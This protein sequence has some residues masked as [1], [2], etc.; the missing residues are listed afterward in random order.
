MTRMPNT[1]ATMK[2]DRAWAKVGNKHYIHVSGNEVSYDCNAW[3][4]RVNS[5]NGYTTLWV[6]KYEAERM[7]A[8]ND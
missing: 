8:Y 3:L 1:A 4:W 5:K 7:G 2:Q 6:A